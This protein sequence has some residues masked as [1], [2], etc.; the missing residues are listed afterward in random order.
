MN[1]FKIIP[2]KHLFKF[3]MYDNKDFYPSIKE[4]LLQEAIKFVKPYISI[5]N[6]NIKAIF[7]ATKSLLFYNNKPQVIKGASNTDV[8]MRAY[9]GSEVCDLIG[10]LMFSLI[11]K[12]INESYWALQG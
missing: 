2:N 12:H 4:K 3:S 7:H 1:L 8:T 6:K 10:I 5:T 11:S 9:S